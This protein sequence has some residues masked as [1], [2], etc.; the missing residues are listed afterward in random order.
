MKIVQIQDSRNQHIVAVEHDGELRC[1]HRFHD[2]AAISQICHTVERD[3]VRVGEAPF[4]AE[5]PSLVPILPRIAK[6]SGRKVF[7]IDDAAW[8]KFRAERDAGLIS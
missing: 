8:E 1:L 3:L 2:A 7:D 4:I 6:G 5:F